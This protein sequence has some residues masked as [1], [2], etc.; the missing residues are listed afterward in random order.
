MATG[1]SK[2]PAATRKTAT[3]K[4]PSKAAAATPAAKTAAK[5]AARRPSP[6]KAAAPAPAAPA[7]LPDLRKKELIEMVVEQSGQK[8]KDAKPVVEAMLSVLGE[9]L[10]SGRELNLQPF[11]KLRIN[12]SEERSNGR[13]I[14]CKLRQAKPGSEKSQ[15]DDISAPAPLAEPEGGR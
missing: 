5:P 13:I 8:K 15:D 10:A 1:T 3:R 9:A 2:R 12:R 7:A 14:V 11:G 4:A 6:V